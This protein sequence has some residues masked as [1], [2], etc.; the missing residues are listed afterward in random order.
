MRIRLSSR[1]PS[2]ITSGASAAAPKTTRAGH[3][4]RPIMGR[5][6][7]QRFSPALAKE[8]GGAEHEHR[9]EQHEVDHFLPRAPEEVR[10]DYLDRGHDQAPDQ[11]SHHVPEAAKHD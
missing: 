2:R 9:D 10:T 8:A 11:G 3:S 4:R 7:T 5:S 1:K 6:G